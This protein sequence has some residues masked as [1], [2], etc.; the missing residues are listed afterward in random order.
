M[1]RVLI[2]DDHPVVRLG[3]ER[4]LD[5]LEGVEVVATAAGGEEAVLASREHQ[6]DVVLIDLQ[7]PGELDGIA[8]TREIVRAQPGV[9]VVVLTSHLDRSKIEAAFAAGAVGYKLKDG[10]PAQLEH[11]VR[12]AADGDFPIAPKA[13]RLLLAHQQQV[14]ETVVKPM[15]SQRERDVLGLVAA[16]CP[17]KEIARRLWITE[18]TVKGHLTKIFREIGVDD[19]HPGCAVGPAKRHRG[20]RR[21]RGTDRDAVNALSRS[22][23]GRSAGEGDQTRERVGR[24]TGLL[25]PREVP[26]PGECDQLGARASSS[27]VARALASR[28]IGSRMPWRNTAGTSQIGECCGEAIDLGF[29]RRH[30]AQVGLHGG[31]QVRRERRRRRGIAEVGGPEQHEA[32]PEVVVG[33]RPCRLAGVELVELRARGGIDARHQIRPE[34]RAAAVADAAQGADREHAPDAPGVP[35]RELEREVA[36]QECPTN[37]ARSA[38]TVSST[39]IASATWRSTSNGPSSVDGA[40]PRCW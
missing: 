35:R 25:E 6:P 29:D 13:A 26:D 21:V 30:R 18:R 32:A 20:P 3:V 1:I 39:A 37:Q 15:L 8:A 4:A 31:A 24:T 17:N 16:G 9:R 10:D 28:S 34:G 33:R 27:A 11:A 14:E 22:L 23:S 38:P 2:V 19:R 7:M 5:G 12:V 40:S 36:A